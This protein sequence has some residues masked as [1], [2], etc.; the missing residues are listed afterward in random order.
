VAGG[1]NF[2]DSRASRIKLRYYHKHRGFVAEYGR[3]GCVG[4]GR[5]ITACP[6]DIHISDVI[7]KLRGIQNAPSR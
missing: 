2:R 3:P 6:V 5:C 7:A 4:C 1:E